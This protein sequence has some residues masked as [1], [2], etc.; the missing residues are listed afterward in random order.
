MITVLAAALV[1]ASQPAPAEGADAAEAEPTKLSE[2]ERRKI[3]PPKFVSGDRAPYSDEA[4]ALGHH[5]EV[6]ILVSVDE[7]GRVRSAQVRQTSH[8]ELLDASALETARSAQFTPALDAEGQPM[9]LD[10]I[11]P[12]EFY[13]S[14]SSEPGGGLV[15][16]SCADFTLD[17]D[18]WDSLGLT[19]DRGKPEKTQLETM[20][21]GLRTISSG[22]RGSIFPTDPKAFVKMMEDHR[23]NW[24]KAR[25]KCR[26]NPDQMLIKYLD[27]RKQIER[28]S[29]MAMRERH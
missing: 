22:T 29:E 24:S 3:T 19:N 25:E 9:P 10:L 13:K 15:R 16:Y 20:L 2:E 4:K 5:G 26:A 8:S 7:S 6:R 1:A 27:N 11:V 23:K 17:T 12:Y 21:L 14:K 28:M 18:W